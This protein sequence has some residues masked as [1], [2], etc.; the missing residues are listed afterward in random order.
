VNCSKIQIEPKNWQQSRPKMKFTI[1][2]TQ[3]RNSLCSQCSPRR[4]WPLK[5]MMTLSTFTE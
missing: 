4:C 2:V 1:N 5:N 3:R